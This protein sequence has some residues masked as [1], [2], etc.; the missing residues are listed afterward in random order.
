MTAP[1]RHR[2]PRPEMASGPRAADPYRLLAGWVRTR[3]PA[4]LDSHAATY[5]PLTLP[6]GHGD[7]VR[8][9]LIAA[10]TDAGLRGRGGGGFLTGRK[11]RAV[12]DAGG[13]STVVV[14]ACEGEPVSD[15]DR[16]LLSV[17]AHLVLDGAVLA[18]HAVRATEIV[19]CVHRGDDLAD[20][21]YEAFA[22]RPDVGTSVRV[23]EV[24]RRYVSSEESALVRFL[25]TGDARPTSKPPHSS[26]RGAAGRPTLV[27]NAETLA[28]LALIARYGAA[29]FRSVGTADDPGSTLVT[30]GGA[31]ETPGVYETARGTPLGE[32]LWLAGPPVGAVQAV[33]VGGYS[34]GWLPLPHAARVPLTHEALAEAGAALGPG[35]LVV[36]PERSCGLAETARILRYFAGE[37]A[38]Q[39][40]PCM[41]GL[42]AI[43]DDMDLLVTGAAGVVD[44]EDRLQRRLPVITGRGACGHPDGAV[45]LAASALRVFG[46]DLRAHSAGNPCPAAARAQLPLPA[47]Q[48]RSGGWR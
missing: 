18:A 8:E 32:V 5:G 10:V 15:K 11:L 13:K 19:V 9:R 21:V 3:S 33:L 37:S 48:H 42:P 7:G 2:A 45:R 36:L 40:G 44:A 39:C 22:E 12:A 41:F 29:W 28:H 34:G 26:E 38:A 16:A 4:G 30:I 6:A 20:R 31:V 25:N 14:N 43:A 23:T 35:A 47:W 1:A 17:A 24:P 46:D 27:D